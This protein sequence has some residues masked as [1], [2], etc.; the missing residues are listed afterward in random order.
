MTGNQKEDVTFSERLLGSLTTMDVSEPTTS[1]PGTT[2]CS[3]EALGDGKAGSWGTVQLPSRGTLA[4]GDR[5]S[6][7]PGSTLSWG[8]CGD[9][10]SCLCVRKSEH[11]LPASRAERLEMA[12]GGKRKLKV[13]RR[14]HLLCSCLKNS[15]CGSA[16]SGTEEILSLRQEHTE[17]L[18]GGH[19]GGWSCR[20]PCGRIK[21][22]AL[23][24]R[25]VHAAFQLSAQTRKQRRC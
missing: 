2:D 1:G 20:R 8:A 16:C 22:W 6:C 9:Q 21:P 10:R 4:G 18:H 3:P 5:R 24:T 23:H 12:Q 15:L 13:S 25:N 17:P 14:R 19:P 11:H 7:T